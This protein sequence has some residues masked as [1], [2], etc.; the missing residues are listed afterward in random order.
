VV[1]KAKQAGRRVTVFPVVRRDERHPKDAKRTFWS[2]RGAGCY[3]RRSDAVRG[4]RRRHGASVAIVFR[5]A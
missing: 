4:A 5:Q 1:S 3:T 2:F